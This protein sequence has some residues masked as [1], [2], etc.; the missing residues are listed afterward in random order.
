[1]HSWN[2]GGG[3]VHIVDPLFDTGAHGLGLP[4]PGPGPG[5]DDDDDDENYGLPAGIM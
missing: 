1:M 5:P 3:T 4:G 2:E